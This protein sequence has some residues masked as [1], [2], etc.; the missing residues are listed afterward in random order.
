LLP[1]QPPKG[2]EALRERFEVAREEVRRGD[3]PLQVAEENLRQGDKERGKREE[4]A[5]K[6]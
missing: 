5:R 3:T 1:P 4:R 2:G 6:G